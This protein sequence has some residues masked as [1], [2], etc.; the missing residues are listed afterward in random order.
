MNLSC[1]T[2]PLGIIVFA[3]LLL[4][5]I[6]LYHL[7]VHDKSCKTY[8]EW[9]KTLPSDVQGQLRDNQ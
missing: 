5:G 6:E 8:T 7:S 4:A 2:R 1:C 3:I 9:I